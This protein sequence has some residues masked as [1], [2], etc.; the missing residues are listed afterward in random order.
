MKE[1][2]DLYWDDAMVEAEQKNVNQTLKQNR[3]LGRNRP[4]AEVGGE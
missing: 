2:L 4:S 1:E 3:Q